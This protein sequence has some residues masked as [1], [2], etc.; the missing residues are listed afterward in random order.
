MALAWGLGFFLLGGLLLGLAGAQTRAEV[1]EAFS[2]VTT[3]LL[4]DFGLD[5][6]SLGD[7]TVSDP[8]GTTVTAD[9]IADVVAASAAASRAQV[10]RQVLL[11]LPVLAVVAG[12]AGWWLASRAIGPVSA[13]TAHARRVSSD[14]LDTRIDLH[15]PDD[16]LKLLA[17]EFDSMMERLEHAFHAQQQ[18]AA[19]ASHELRTPL[20]V[21]RTELDVALDVPDPTPDDLADMGTAIRAALDRSE[22]TIDSLLALARSGVAQTSAQVD[23]TNVVDKCLDDTAQQRAERRISVHRTGDTVATVR[24]DPSLLDR[25]VGNLVQNAT[26]HNVDGGEI[27]ID[28]SGSSTG[29]TLTITNTGPVLTSVERLGEPF[30]RADTSTGR[31]GS[32][33]GLVVA[34]SIA[35]AHR[36]QIT[37]R[38]N[39]GGGLAVA[40]R[41]PA[42]HLLSTDE[43]PDA[44]P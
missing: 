6:D 14:S 4:T 13:M 27:T 20:T 22:R 28:L 42:R 30:Y 12:V 40:L 25:M 21:I 8:S 7:L 5:A 24:G 2:T 44:L 36:G 33:L 19:S 35:R 16:E 15:G 1:G 3:S 34:D 10:S 32:G 11:T 9:D 39:P 38:P 43:Q 41:L 26:L 17:D 37:L 31:A 29:V 18:F 23:L